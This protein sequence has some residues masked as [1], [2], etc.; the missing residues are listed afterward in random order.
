[1]KEAL[2]TQRVGYILNALVTVILVSMADI[3]WMDLN[4]ITF[5][6]RVLVTILLDTLLFMSGFSVLSNLQEV[7]KKITELERGL[8]EE[9]Q[10]PE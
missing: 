6:W 1:M 3:L 8:K 2:E 10:D 5:V 4:E 9:E 7:E